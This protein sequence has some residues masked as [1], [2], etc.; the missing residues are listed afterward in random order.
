LRK[1]NHQ[2]KRKANVQKGKLSS[3]KKNCMDMM[4]HD[5]GHVDAIFAGMP[6]VA[7]FGGGVDARLKDLV[8][9]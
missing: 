7:L 1:R 3:Q 4:T 6:F 2:P 9:S 8:T 5:L